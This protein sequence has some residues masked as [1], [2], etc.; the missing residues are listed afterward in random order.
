MDKIFGFL[1]PKLSFWVIL[2][3]VGIIAGVRIQ[4]SESRTNAKTL[5]A[6]LASCSTNLGTSQGNEA[7][8]DAALKEQDAKIKAMQAEGRRRAADAKAASDK[9]L[10]RSEE[11]KREALRLGSGPDVMNQW[12]KGIFQ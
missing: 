3:L 12:Q 8:L 11:R 9:A 10:K 6:N 4:L 5:A 7:R 1:T 2:A